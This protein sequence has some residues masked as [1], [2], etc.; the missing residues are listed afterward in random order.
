MVLDSAQHGLDVFAGLMTANVNIQVPGV[1][2]PSACSHDRTTIN[3]PDSL[4]TD[5][6]RVTHELGHVI[7]MQILA[8]DTLRSD[9]SKSGEGW[10][11]T[12]DEYDSCASQEGL[13]TYAGLGAVQK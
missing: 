2:C 1:N 9:Y 4:T 8:Q 3:I 7:Q 13:A 12:S 10:S 5:G 6:I 11:P